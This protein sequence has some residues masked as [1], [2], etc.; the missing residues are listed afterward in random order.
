MADGPDTTMWRAI[1]SDRGLTAV[2][3][4]LICLSSPS[5]MSPFPKKEKDSDGTNRLSRDLPPRCP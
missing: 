4:C 1:K 2:M 3:C 5:L